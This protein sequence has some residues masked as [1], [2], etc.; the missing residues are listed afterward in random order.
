VVDVGHEILTEM[1]GRT[2]LVG[3]ARPKT[4]RG[5]RNC[6]WSLTPSSTRLPDRLGERAPNP[7]TWDPSIGKDI[8]ENVSD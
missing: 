2:W 5:V 8:G 3:A 1:S 7:L 4:G 6:V